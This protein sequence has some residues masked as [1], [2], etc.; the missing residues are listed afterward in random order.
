[1]RLAA[2]ASGLSKS[3]IHRVFQLFA[4][5][6]HRSESFKLFTDP[7]FVEKVWDVVGLYLNR[8]DHAVVL[9]VDDSISSKLAKLCMRTA[10][11][12]H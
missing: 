6:P 12:E 7:F 9:S 2:A 3:T 10:G 1:V 4:L 11:T 8:R 5:Q